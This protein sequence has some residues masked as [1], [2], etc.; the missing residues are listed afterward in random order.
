VS[1]RKPYLNAAGKPV[2]SVTQVISRFKDSG[3][4]IWWAWNEGREGRDFRETQGAAA[5]AGT[6]AHKM[7][8]CEI[9]GQA[10]QPNGEPP[11]TLAKASRAFAMFQ[12]WSRHTQLVPVDTEVKLVSEELQVG[13][14]I[15]AV[16]IL[17]KVALLD[18]KAS[19]AVYVD[20]LIQI[21]AYGAL[22]NEHNPD[23]PITGGYHLVRF[24]KDEGDFSQHYFSDL[25]DALESF[26]LMRRLFDLDKKLKARVK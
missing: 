1:E 2:P 7:V 24:S 17:D 4:L 23:R 19:N 9:R 5:S 15:D 11:E 25:S 20:Y 22:W 12:E 18:W 14:T 16:S 21:A 6:L 13:G 26:K 8:E 3:G 10:F